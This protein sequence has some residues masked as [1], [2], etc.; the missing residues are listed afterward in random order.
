[1]AYAQATIVKLFNLSS[2]LKRNFI[3]RS[4]IV[5]FFI[6][7][8]IAGLVGFTSL[9][10]MVAQ[11]SQNIF[12]IFAALFVIVSGYYII[13][14]R[15]SALSFGLIFLAVT[16]VSGVVAFTNLT[17]AMVYVAKISFYIFLALFI[18]SAT[19]HALRKRA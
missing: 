9:A 5:T 6:L 17:S 7:A 13:S 15:S 4:W 1:M 14:K 19:V 3:M 12:F 2:N 10:S 18:I 16:V 11:F 8:V